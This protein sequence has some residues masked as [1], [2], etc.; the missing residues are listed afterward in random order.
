MALQL[1][2]YLTASHVPTTD[3]TFLPFFCWKRHKSVFPVNRKHFKNWLGGW[4]A[5]GIIVDLSY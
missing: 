5:Y 4:P 2:I 3:V 1:S